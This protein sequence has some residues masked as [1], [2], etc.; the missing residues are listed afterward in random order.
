MESEWPEQGPSTS[1]RAVGGL[2]T[3]L[4]AKVPITPLL[5]RFFLISDLKFPRS[6]LLSA[7]ESEAAIKEI[8]QMTQLKSDQVLKPMALIKSRA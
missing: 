7:I 6:L 3:F 2:S 8:S 5:V 4:R 1:L